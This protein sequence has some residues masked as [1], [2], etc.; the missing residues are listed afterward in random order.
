MPRCWA[1]ELSQLVDHYP[2]APSSDAHIRRTTFGP[3]SFGHASVSITQD[4]Y[5]HV[6]PSMIEEAGERLDEIVLSRRLREATTF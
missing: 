6:I 4:I 5:Q 1:V 3:R 2:G